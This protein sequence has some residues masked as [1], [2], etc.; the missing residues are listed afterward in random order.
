MIIA[1]DGPSGSGKSTV[2]IKVAAALGFGYLDTGALYRAV[3]LAGGVPQKLE[4]TTAAE[5]ARIWVDGAEVS[6]AIRTPE[7][8]AEVSRWAADPDIRTYVTEKI[9]SLI[10]G[11]FVV[12][13]RDIGSVVAPDAELKIYLTADE[14]ARAARRASEWKSDHSLAQSSISSRD[15]V[16][17]SR[18][19]APLR[20]AE[21]AIAI[22]STSMSVDEV[23]ARIVSLAKERL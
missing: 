13:G 22:D 23:V 20:Q 21:D 15:A 16:D 8:T 17:S 19:V 6:G 1:I 4:I 3:A 2:S 12:E 9:R 11:N 18:T 5:A 14:Q 7:V 10:T